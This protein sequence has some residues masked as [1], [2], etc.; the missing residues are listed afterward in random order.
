[1]LDVKKQKVGEI[2]G[3]QD[4]LGGRGVVENNEKMVNLMEVYRR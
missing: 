4:R 1:M 2:E 3:W